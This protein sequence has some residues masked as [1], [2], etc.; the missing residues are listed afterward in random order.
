M[1][2]SQ[3]AHRRRVA[4]Q[5]RNRQNSGTRTRPAQRGGNH[6]R[7]A[8]RPHR[9]QQPVRPRRASRRRVAAITGA[10]FLI[11]ATAG[12]QLAIPPLITSQLRAKLQK[13]A[14]VRSLSIS[15]FPAVE[16]LWGHLDSVRVHLGRVNAQQLA[17]RPASGGASSGLAHG[18]GSGLARMAGGV[19]DAS[20][21]VDQIALGHPVAQDLN[22]QKTGPHLRLS[23]LLD[24]TAIGPALARTLGLPAGTDVQLTAAQ[25]DPVLLL[26]S[27]QF[28]GEI[29]LKIL[30]HDGAL[31]AQLEPT[32]AMAARLGLPVGTSPPAQPLLHTKTLNIS[33]LTATWHGGHL[34]I[35]ATGQLTA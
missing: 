35:A 23:V 20:V 4:R 15:A 1:G 29:H 5:R 17:G 25:S 12:S 21:E 6:G 14:T 9:T 19:T 27:P 11:M 13:I 34:R 8:A 10:A 28:G 18:A 22:L 33:Q 30:A 2:S 26:N 31:A 16:A 32:P 7:I 24:P 3:R